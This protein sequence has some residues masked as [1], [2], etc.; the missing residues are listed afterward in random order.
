MPIKLSVG[1]DNQKAQ[2]LYRKLRFQR[3]DEL[4]GDDLIFLYEESDYKGGCAI[5]HSPLL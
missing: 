4:D 1:A 5:R 2:A 3:L